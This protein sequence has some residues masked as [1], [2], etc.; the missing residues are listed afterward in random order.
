MA[1]LTKMAD[2]NG[3]VPI[4]DPTDCQ[5]WV[6]KAGADYPIDFDTFF[7]YIYRANPSESCDGTMGQVIAYSET[8]L[9][10]KPQIF[11]FLG[12]GIEVTAWDENG[13]TINSYGAG[14]FGY[15]TIKSR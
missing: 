12:I 6:S 14:T 2:L 9:N 4:D 1:E 3:G 15:L 11:D 7:R 13:F 10:V 8:F 5:F